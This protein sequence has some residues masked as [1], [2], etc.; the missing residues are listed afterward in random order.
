MGLTASVGIGSF[1]TS[2][3]AE[4]NILQLCANLD[5]RVITTVTEHKDELKSYVHTP[6]KG[7][8]IQNTHSYNLSFMIINAI[9]ACDS[10]FR[11]S[12]VHESPLHQNNQKH[13]E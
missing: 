7:Q 12:T 10:F 3:E 1:K 6:E 13:H 11:G 4:N 2:L 5:T 9:C 8:R